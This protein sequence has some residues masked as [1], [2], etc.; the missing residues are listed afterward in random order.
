LYGKLYLSPVA[1]GN[2]SDNFAEELKLCNPPGAKESQGFSVFPRQ[3]KPGNLEIWTLPQADIDR[4]KTTHKAELGIM[5]LSFLAC[6]AYKDVV[7]QTWH[8]TP[9]AFVVNNVSE[10][11]F[12]GVPFDSQGVST[13]REVLQPS[14]WDIASPF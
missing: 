1:T 13:G 11:S 8:G 2:T 6:L 5:P 14:P 10:N 9:A 4:F 3:N 7:S 12:S